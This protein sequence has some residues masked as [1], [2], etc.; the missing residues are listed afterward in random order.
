MSKTPTIS[1]IELDKA[2]HTL[3]DGNRDA[4]NQQMSHTDYRTIIAKDDDSLMRCFV[5]CCDDLVLTA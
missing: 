2:L 4:R 3:F 5:A 1:E